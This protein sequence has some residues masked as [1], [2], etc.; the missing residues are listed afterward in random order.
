MISLS[1]NPITQGHELSLYL[2]RTG[3]VWPHLLLNC[4]HLLC[5][6]TAARPWPVPPS[7]LEAS[8]RDRWVWALTSSLRLEANA[9]LSLSGAD[10]W[11][12]EPGALEAPPPRG[13]PCPWQTLKQMGKDH[14]SC[15]SSLGSGGGWY[16]LSA[17]V[18]T[19]PTGSGRPAPASLCVH[20]A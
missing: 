7:L 12:W 2:N 6:V 18:W 14:L 8:F 13:R 15:L 10:P 9:L 16:W 17:P 3:R 5:K 1:H 11:G 4:L 20:R 19:P